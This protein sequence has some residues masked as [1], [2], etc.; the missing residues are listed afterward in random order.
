MA[1]G[2]LFPDYCRFFYFWQHGSH[3]HYKEKATD[4]HSRQLLHCQP[5]LCQPDDHV[6][7]RITGHS[8]EDSTATRFSGQRLVQIF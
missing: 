7:E 3:L 1:T 6:S 8:W 2:V 4:A 5:V